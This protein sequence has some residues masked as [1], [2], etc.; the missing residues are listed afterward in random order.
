MH[1][2]VQQV[3]C[4]KII[5]PF[6]CT[7]IPD[8]LFTSKTKVNYVQMNAV[9]GVPKTSS[10]GNS[11][12]SSRM[13]KDCL[14][15]FGLASLPCRIFLAHLSLSPSFFSFFFC[16]RVNVGVGADE[17]LGVEEVLGASVGASS[18]ESKPGGAFTSISKALGRLHL[19]V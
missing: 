9:P 11:P 14:G 10:F 19:Q 13:I 18:S 2:N 7:G 1:S 8:D 12:T 17:V 4:S 3:Q 6:I 16:W 15:V 5:L